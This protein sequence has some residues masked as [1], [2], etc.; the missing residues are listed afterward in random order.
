M[1]ATKMVPGAQD[2]GIEA[3]RRWCRKLGQWTAAMKM[4]PA[5]LTGRVTGGGGD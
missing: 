4:V 5:A 3:Q 1:A 2:R